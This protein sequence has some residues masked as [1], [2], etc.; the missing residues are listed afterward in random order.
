MIGERPISTGERPGGNA[1][2][3]IVLVLAVCLGLA[4]PA[5]AK[6]A[7]S[8]WSLCA[9]ASQAR[10]CRPIVKPR[11]EPG[12]PITTLTRLYRPPMAGAETVVRIQA[13]A[14]SE[15][16][17]NG[18]LLGRNGRVGADPA[19]ERPGRFTAEFIVP[20]AWVRAD[21]NRVTVR[22]SAQ[23]LWPP[24][25]SAVHVLDVGP[26]Q[27]PLRDLVRRYLPTL[28]MMGLIALAFGH[29]I[30]LAWRDDDQEAWLIAALAG[31]VLTQAAF[32]ASRLL[33]NYPYPFHTPRLAAIAGL[34]AVT[35]V[36]T[37]RIAANR[38]ASAWRNSVTAVTAAL[39]VAALVLSPPYDDKAVGAMIVGATMA[40]GCAG[41]G[42]V[43]RI[44]GAR[45]AFVAFGLVIV[46]ASLDGGLFLDAGCYLAFAAAFSWRFAA[47]AIALRQSKAAELDLRG[48]TLA[49]E[50][51]LE[52][53][54]GARA[55]T[56]P[57]VI[58]DGARLHR[59]APSKIAYLKACDDYVEVCQQDGRRL[60]APGGLAA[61]L[62]RLPPG[63]E[64]V[65]RGYVV[66]LACVVAIERDAGG[67]RTVLLQGGER[68]P[69]GRKHASVLSSLS[70]PAPRRELGRAEVS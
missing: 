30:G 15:V 42:V 7:G 20:S 54:H 43:R 37:A 23:H 53:A 55:A 2:Q 35:S 9:F 28:G 34:A 3:T 60:L 31:T 67:R 47:D 36:L 18:A 13:M 70:A 59:I 66:N 17:W 61:M 56:E 64:R 49:A 57:L 33:V 21:Q 32:E 14:S 52:R 1:I 38:F 4:Q 26:R 48:R 8:A 25:A 62:G 50:T 40:L 6:A 41:W 51:A 69:V 39:A 22:L 58:R 46:A 16:W 29:A 44:P 24:V 12:A 65:H 10:D 45:A 63:F 11:L 5:Y 27:D 68:L 19:A